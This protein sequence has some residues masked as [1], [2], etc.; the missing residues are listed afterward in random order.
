MISVSRAVAPKKDRLTGKNLHGKRCR[1]SAL[2]GNLRVREAWD[3]EHQRIAG[4]QHPGLAMAEI[5]TLDE[6]F[7]ELAAQFAAV[8]SGSSGVQGAWPKVL[9]TR[10][11]DGRWCPDPVV[12]D[13]DATDHVIVKWIGDKQIESQYIL[14]AEAPYLELARVFGIHIRREPRI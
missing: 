12:P 7:L 6:R 8:A 3:L 5:T 2:C 1:N 10:R 14:A 11:R 4:E 9:L 13:E